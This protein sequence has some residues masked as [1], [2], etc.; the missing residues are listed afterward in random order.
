[1]INLCKANVAHIMAP[2]HSCALL[3]ALTLCALPH[4]Y[5]LTLTYMYCFKQHGKGVQGYCCGVEF[6]LLLQ[7]Q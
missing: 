1:M 2:S 5:P 3:S 7:C 4:S 6:H